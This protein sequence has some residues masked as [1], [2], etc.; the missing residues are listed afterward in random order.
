MYRKIVED[1]IRLMCIFVVTV[2]MF[3]SRVVFFNV[4]Y[5]R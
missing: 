1:I 5:S 2:S 4:E 3:V